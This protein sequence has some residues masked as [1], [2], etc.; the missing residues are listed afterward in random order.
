MAVAITV[1]GMEPVALPALG[2]LASVNAALALTHAA[3]IDGS[4][5]G[6]DKRPLAGR[7]EV[8]DNHVVGDHVVD[9]SHGGRDQAVYSYA[10]E[11]AAWWANELQ[12]EVTP[13][14][15]GENLSTAGVDVT[16]AVIGERWA[17]GSAVLEVSGPRIPC[18]TFAG[19]WDVPD[20]IK[21]FTVEGRSG[22]Y[23]RIL[24][25]GEV[26][27]GDEIRVVHRPAHGVSIGEVFRALTG[28]R[29]LAPRLLTAPELP[30]KHRN[31][32]EKWLSAAEPA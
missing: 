31:K 15:F 3:W 16:G 20:L 18:R 12:R 1:D 24:T 7:V 9:G 5:T 10:R 32:V 28:D 4:P 27:A 14:A 25:E 13:G 22:A 6:I 21:R 23:L 29:A 11:D 19:F 8:R 2:R 26:G 30:T 17:I